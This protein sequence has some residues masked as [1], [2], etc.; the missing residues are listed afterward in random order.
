MRIIKNFK[1]RKIIKKILGRE[2]INTIPKNNE[3]DFTFDDKVDD[4]LLP[5]PSN[6][7]I[8]MNHN[9]TEIEN[10]RLNN[11][12]L[13]IH[14]EGQCLCLFILLLLYYASIIATKIKN[15]FNNK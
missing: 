4:V 7:T 12:L 11:P 9:V 2:K 14:N 1:N 15:T 3:L 5:L 6:D 13:H 8:M 10:S